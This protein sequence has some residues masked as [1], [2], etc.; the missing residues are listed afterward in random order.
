MKGNPCSKAFPME[1]SLFIPKFNFPLKM[2]L[3]AFKTF[4]F[5]GTAE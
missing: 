2:V 3:V 5:N 1:A 4:T